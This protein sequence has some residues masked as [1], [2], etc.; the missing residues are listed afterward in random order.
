L[1][2]V[3]ISPHYGDATDNGNAGKKW[4]EADRE[5]KKKEVKASQAKMLAEMIDER[6]VEGEA[7]REESEHEIRGS[8]AKM[9]AEIREERKRNESPHLPDRGQ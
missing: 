6:R 3:V 2:C 8:Q 7:D 5:E 9:L 4:M 1:H